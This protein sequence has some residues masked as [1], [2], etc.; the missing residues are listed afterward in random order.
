MSGATFSEISENVKF[1]RESALL[2]NYE[3]AQVYYQAVLQQLQKL[4]ATA[5]DPACRQ[6]WT[7]V[8][9]IRI[10]YY[11]LPSTKIMN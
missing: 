9:G 5:N 10:P 1:G 2:G 8:S 3:S 7:Q 6:R 4:L 11:V